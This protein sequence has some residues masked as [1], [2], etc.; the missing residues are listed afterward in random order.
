MRPN[1]YFY[2]YYYSFVTEIDPVLVIF[3]PNNRSR[4]LRLGPGMRDTETVIRN[5][6]V[7]AALK[8]ETTSSW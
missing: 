6:K 3:P 1:I 8:G 7:N 4:Y 2:L 5:I